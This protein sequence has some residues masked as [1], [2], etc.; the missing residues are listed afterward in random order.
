MNS[1]AEFYTVNLARAP[2][3]GFRRVFATRRHWWHGI[4]SVH[5][6][7]RFGPLLHDSPTTNLPIMA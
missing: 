5:S 6:H 1:I 3:A 4:Q 7:S 2:T